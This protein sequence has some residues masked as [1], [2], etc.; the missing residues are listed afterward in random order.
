MN[1]T[2]NTS[3]RLILGICGCSHS[4]KVTVAT[5]LAQEHNFTHL[6]LKRDPEATPSIDPDSDESVARV[7]TLTTLVEVAL[8]ETSGNIVITGLRH[9]EEAAWITE[10]G[11]VTLRV[12]RPEFSAE[13]IDIDAD[14]LLLNSGNE[15]DLYEQAQ[16]LVDELLH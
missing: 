9:K 12:M 16:R 5:L 4:G 15:S 6:R 7:N 8:A 13:A 10:Q 14:H 11:G 2:T 1:P 3:P